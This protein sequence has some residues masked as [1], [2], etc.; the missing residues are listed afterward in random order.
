MFSFYARIRFTQIC[1]RESLGSLLLNPVR[2][3]GK[4]KSGSFFL[5]IQQTDI[6][7]D[8]DF[9]YEMADKRLQTRLPNVNV[10]SSE[11]LTINGLTRCS[12]YIFDASSRWY[13]MD[14][15]VPFSFISLFT[16]R[17]KYIPYSRNQF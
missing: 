5:V 4:I 15:C 6:E 2:Q 14:N 1:C 17:E 3:F 7:P 12:H 11:S 8:C 10:D 9:E 16:E 13:S